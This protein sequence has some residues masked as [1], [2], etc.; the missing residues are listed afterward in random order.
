[1]I[2]SDVLQRF[3]A[4]N[5]AI[6]SGWV[7]RNEVREREGFNPEPGLDVFLEPLNVQQVGATPTGPATPPRSPAREPQPSGEEDDGD[8][9]ASIFEAYRELVTERANRLVRKEPTRL[10]FLAKKYPEVKALE[11]AIK[12]FYSEFAGADAE[13]KRE[14]KRQLSTW[15]AAGDDLEMLLVRWEHERAVEIVEREMSKWR[16]R[17]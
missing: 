17:T 10:R 16:D 9:R 5:A 7:K 15:L 3:Q 2:V 4:W 6:I 1:L 11:L 8:E 12:T 14:S 13:Y